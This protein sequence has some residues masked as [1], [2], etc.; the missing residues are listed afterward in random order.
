[1]SLSR[2]DKNSLY[3]QNWRRPGAVSTARQLGGFFK[4]WPPSQRR[5]HGH[6]ARPSRSRAGKPLSA[7]YLLDTD[8][9]VAL[10]RRNSPSLIK[11]LQSI[12]PNHLA[13]SMVT[14]AELQYGVQA[15][16]RV[17]E[18]PLRCCVAGQHI[19]ALDWNHEA[20]MHYAHIRHALKTKGKLIGS[21]D[22][23]IAAHA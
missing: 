10:L 21:N 6:A 8:I 11:R 5:F 1:M 7:L 9:C 15:C 3:T 12:S 4:P 13:M 18:K 19:K 17:E 2:D 22:L 20:A 16:N 14:W 23:M